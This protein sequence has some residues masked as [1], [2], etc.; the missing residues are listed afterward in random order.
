MPEQAAQSPRTR[1][2][3]AEWRAFLRLGDWLVLALALSLC[4]WSAVALWQPGR[5][6]RVQVRARG[7][8]VADLALTATRTLEVQGALGVSRIEIR[9][10]QV[11]VAADPGPRQYCVRQG[12]LKRPGAV[13]ICAPNAVT[14][15]LTG[16]GVEYDSLNY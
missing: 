4:G 12:W 8:L 7:E 1:M 16:G 6:E 10:G 5:A 13:A 14:L 9:A 2:S 15:R 3:F 11:R